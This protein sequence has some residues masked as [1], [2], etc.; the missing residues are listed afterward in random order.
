MNQASNR[1]LDVIKENNKVIKNSIIVISVFIIT[2]LSGDL[3][4][5][6]T[7]INPPSFPACNPEIFNE[8]GDW[9]SY[10]T[11]VHGIPGIGNLEGSDDVYSLT[12]GNFLQCFCPV[13]GSTGIQT[14]WWNIQRAGLT[15]NQVSQFTASG[16]I[17]EGSGLG[18]NLF[19]EKYLVKNQEFNCRELP[20]T[21][22]LTPVPTVTPTPTITPTPKPEPESR[23]VSLSI[24]PNDG[25][26]P[27]TVRF[28]GSGFNEDGNIQRYRFDF[29]DSS[30]GQTQV[31]EQDGS[32]AYHRYEYAGTYTASLSVKDSRGNWRDGQ[33]DCKKTITVREQPRV[34]GAELPSQLP[35]AGASLA[36]IGGIVPLG[37]YLY[38]RFKIV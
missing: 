26:A 29:G 38:K 6:Q 28:N 36:F 27:L 5:A 12:A 13:S 10:E 23:C 8:R 24:S 2:L 9:A 20:P 21:P 37:Y 32:E 1:I 35:K 16:W 4:L 34:L 31:W 17:Y 22:T 33:S 7:S 19:D 30:G 18:W 25:T 3:I 14:N 11:G 15:D